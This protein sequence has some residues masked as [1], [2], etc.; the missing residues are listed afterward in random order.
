[1]SRRIPVL[2]D[3]CEREVLAW[4]EPDQGRIMVK[5][6]RHGQTHSV[7]IELSEASVTDLLER[8]EPKPPG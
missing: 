4:I 6:R 8:R 7:S 5:D 1:M 3:C 2:C